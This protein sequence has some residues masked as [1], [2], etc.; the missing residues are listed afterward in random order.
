MHG[1]IAHDVAGQDGAK[2]V[3]RNCNLA[4]PDTEPAGVDKCFLCGRGMVYRGSRFCTSR[5]CKAFDRG[6]PRHDPHHARILMSLP[7]RSWKVA[8]PVPDGLPIGS[9]YYGPILD[10]LRTF[11]KP[12]IRGQKVASGPQPLK[13]KFVENN[14]A[15]SM[16]CEA[17]SR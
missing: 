12:L 6:F 17:I 14:P 9:S 8:A 5:C 10:R 11:R 13:P 4:S 7:L 1:D 16:S 15:A 3:A 2:K